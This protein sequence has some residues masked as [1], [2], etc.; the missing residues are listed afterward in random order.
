MGSVRYHPLTFLAFLLAVFILVFPTEI[1]LLVCTAREREIGQT[2]LIIAGCEAA[3][4]VPLA[5]ATAQTR[6]HPEKWKPRT[7]S[8]VVWGIVI[9][10][11][12]RD[13]LVIAEIVLTK[14]P[15][16]F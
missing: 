10:S 11:L 4:V 14:I 13:A 2:L 9:V 16:M 12:A 6:R 15:K 8:Y 3:V 5:I 7:L 1:D